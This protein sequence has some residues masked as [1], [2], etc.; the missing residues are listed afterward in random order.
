[1]TAHTALQ[2][3]YFL[4]ETLLIAPGI[5]SHEV[6]HLFACRLTGVRVVEYPRFELTAPGA[7]LVHEP[8]DSFPADLLIAVAPLPV[9]T[10]LGIA[11][12]AAA[13]ALSAPWSWPCYWLGICFALTAFP[14]HG[15]T[16]TLTDTA[17]GL[18]QWRRVVGYALAVPVRWFTRVPGSAGVAG[19]AWIF[20]LLAGG[21][22]G[23]AGF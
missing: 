4:F 7:A 23:L 9:N 16:E 6:A 2:R 21:R 15:D 17:G 11:A 19:F 10:A 12:F 1:V 13:T 18:S 8:V 22:L 14:S 3:A 20:V 5:V